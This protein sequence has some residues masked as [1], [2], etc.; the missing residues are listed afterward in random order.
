M[1]NKKYLDVIKNSNQPIAFVLG[2]YLTSGLG[3]V[4]SLGREG[5]KTIVVASDKNQISF[6]SKYANG[7]LCPNPK[8]KEEEYI[9]FLIN[10]GEK[11]KHKGVLLPISDTEAIAI[12]KNQKKLINYYNFTSAGYKIVDKIIN[13]NKFYKILD[14]KKIPHPRTYFPNK[15]TDIED[16]SEKIV[17]P[18]IL[19][20]VYSS[21]FMS[22]FKTKLFKAENK[23]EL[24]N[25][26]K[27]VQDKNHEVNIQEIIPGEANK[28]YGLN[29]FYNHNFNPAG[30]FM[31]RR[32]RGWPIGFGNGCY[33]ESVWQEELEKI[34][35][36]LIKNLK[37]FGIVDVE[38]KKDIRDDLFKIIEINPR[39]WMQNSLPTR[40]G[41]NIP[42]LAYYEAIGKPIKDMILKKD[43]IKWLYMTDDFKSSVY[44]IRE[45]RLTIADWIKSYSGKKEL[46]VFD[47]KD[48]F[49]FIVLFA[50][51]SLMPFTNLIK[52]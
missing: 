49:P 13:K 31:Y 21:Y 8:D 14:D 10:L 37:Y 33:I 24:I 27:I 30:V 1:I 48:M 3:V 28:Q 12:L 43:K 50:R 46:A 15:N 19:K 17:Y 52:K 11:L 42:L 5:I 36:P 6:F 44:N 20:P 41:L 35:T 16:I 38:F 26:Y 9:N 23:N 45:G 18:C 32:I 7:V 34:I 25:C 51:T 29:A 4:R 2:S 39:I 22:D 47:L 40:C